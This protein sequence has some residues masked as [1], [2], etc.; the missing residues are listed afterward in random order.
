MRSQTYC[1]LHNLSA[2]I[3]DLQAAIAR[4]D[5]PTAQ[6]LAASVAAELEDWRLALLHIPPAE[7][8]RYRSANPYYTK[9]S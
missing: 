7:R 3:D 2:T 4:A 8:C 1:R 5:L 9:R 6:S